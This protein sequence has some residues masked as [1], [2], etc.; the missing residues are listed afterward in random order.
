MNYLTKVV[1]FNLVLIGSRGQITADIFSNYGNSKEPTKEPLIDNTESDTPESKDPFARYSSYKEQLS[2][3]EE[4]TNT[5]EE[6]PKSVQVEIESNND[7]IQPKLDSILDELDNLVGLTK[8]KC[9]IKTLL[10]F[11][12]IQE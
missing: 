7:T 2:K 6:K 9:E 8:V 3:L 1:K 11:V 12:K 5:N 10:Q 4:K